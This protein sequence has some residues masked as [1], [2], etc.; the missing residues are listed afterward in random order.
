MGVDCFNQGGTFRGGGSDCSTANC[1]QPGACCLADGTCISTVALACT[2]QG[3]TFH[4]VGST[5]ATIPQCPRSITTSFAGTSST[6]VAG[7]GAYFLITALDPQGLT[8]ESFDINSA[9]AAGT[10]ITAHVYAKAGHFEGFETDPTA[11]FLVGEVQTIAAGVGQPTPVPIGGFSVAAGE[12]WS[13]RVGAGNGG[14]RYTG[15]TTPPSYENS[16]LRLDM[17]KVQTALFSGTLFGTATSLRGWDG[18]IWYDLGTSVMGACCLPNGT[19]GDFTQAVCTGQGG[20]YR[21]D[22]TT[23][24]TQPACPVGACCLIDGSCIQTAETGCVAQGG[25]Y[26]GDNSDCLTSTCPQPGACCLPGV[27][28]IVIQEVA[29]TAQNGVFSGAG[30]TCSSVTCDQPLF[31]NGAIITQMGVGFQGHHISRASTNATSAGSAVTPSAP[32]PFFRL[33]DDFTV[34]GTGWDIDSIVVHA[35]IT[36]PAAAPYGYPPAS[37]WTGISMNIWNGVPDAPGSTIVASSTTMLSTGFTGVY[38]LF[39]TGVAT[40]AERPIMFVEAGFENVHLAPGTYWIDY[41]LTGAQGAT[42]SGFASYVMEVDTGGLPWTPA[43]N[44]R[45]L[46]DTGWVDIAIDPAPGQPVDFPFVVTGSIGGTAPCYANCDGSTV[47]PV[48]NVDDFTCFVNNFALAQQLPHEQ[49]I[50][51]YANCDGST[52]APV[53]NVEDFTCF[54]NRYAQGCP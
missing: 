47:A 1:P 49:Q 40:N 38:R 27:H 53:L 48:L 11:W 5:C 33:A 39:N 44:A 29:C 30:T 32:G 36:Q 12:T 46:T 41:Q 8:I 2:S 45:Q 42:T 43:G 28:C 13:L 3:G 16:H 6:T 17:G 7:A 10:A 54:V 25:T 37:P 24:A 21:G 9:A 19:C 26:R 34:T 4:G 15:S 35:Y 20:T 52:T 50:T 31:Y 22:N 14:I 51:A 23:C 18:R